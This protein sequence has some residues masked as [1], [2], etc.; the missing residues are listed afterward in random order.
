MSELSPERI[1]PERP[2]SLS[3]VTASE[4]MQVALDVSPNLPVLGT[5]LQ[6]GTAAPPVAAQRASHVNAS[7]LE[8]EKVVVAAPMSLAGSAARIWKLTG[9]HDNPAARIGLGAVAI[10]LIL[11]AWTVVLSWYVMFGLLLVPYRLI[12]RGQRKSKRQA[13]MHRE[14]LAAM[15]GLQR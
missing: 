11:C 4:P 10:F 14:Q 12:R 7:K 8:S 6:P 5:G 2:P 1:A 15:Q 9:M 3:P 13:L